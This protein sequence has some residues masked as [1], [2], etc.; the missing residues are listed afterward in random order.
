MTLIGPKPITRLI[1][2]ASPSTTSLNDSYWSETEPHILSLPQPALVDL[3]GG[4][5]ASIIRP[6]TLPPIAGGGGLAKWREHLGIDHCCAGEA[7]HP[8]D[9]LD[10]TIGIDQG[11]RDGASG[12]VAGIDADAVIDDRAVLAIVVVG[13]NR[14]GPG[15]AL[16]VPG[17][18]RGERELQLD[19]RREGALD[20]DLEDASIF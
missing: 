1:E 10:R 17:T 13:R 15:L 20:D 6:L 5:P 9:T 11:R 12:V 16:V 14:S 7:D 8:G 2:P 18:V 4:W 3:D 19:G